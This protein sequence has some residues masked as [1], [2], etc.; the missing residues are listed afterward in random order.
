MD[1][2]TESVGL[3]GFL[4]RTRVA[5]D[6]AMGR[7]TT[8]WQ[9]SLDHLRAAVLLPPPS[10]MS[11]ARF[12]E[13]SQKICRLALDWNELQYGNIVAAFNAAYALGLLGAG[14]LIDR[15]GTRI[16]YSLALTV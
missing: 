7:E 2:I 9:L 3:P 11:T 8:R 1:E 13:F 14:R 12:W 10:T 16:G 15:F 5:A 4:N 6:A